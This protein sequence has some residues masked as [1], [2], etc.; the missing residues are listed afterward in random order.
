MSRNHR[1]KGKNKSHSD[2]HD[3]R[4]EAE[5]MPDVNAETA[6]DHKDDKK[7]KRPRG[8]GKG[9]GDGKGKRPGGKRPKTQRQEKVEQAEEALPKIEGKLDVPMDIGKFIGAM[10]TPSVRSFL[11]NNLYG[12]FTILSARI[13]LFLEQPQRKTNF[14]L[15]PMIIFLLEASAAVLRRVNYFQRHCRTMLI[16]NSPQVDNSCYFIDGARLPV[17]NRLFNEV[18]ALNLNTFDTKVSGSITLGENTWYMPPGVVT[19]GD[20]Q[21]GVLCAAGV[22]CVRK[23][24]L[25]AQLIALSMGSLEL[26]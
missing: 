7:N 21:P 12:I 5:D 6:K 25:S 9:K 19:Y 20:S 17:F 22:L 15:S 1:R 18:R 10:V 2:R 11:V 4:D 23:F 26:S 13:C 24:I 14:T 3:Y 8:R 16:P